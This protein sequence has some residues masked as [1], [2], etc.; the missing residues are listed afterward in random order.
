MQT[1]NTTRLQ[2]QISAITRKIVKG[3]VKHEY[4]A[5]KQLITLSDH[6]NSIKSFQFLAR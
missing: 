1:I 2:S 5:K 3:K 4:A 6:L